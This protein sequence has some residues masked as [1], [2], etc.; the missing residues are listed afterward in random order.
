MTIDTTPKSPLDGLVSCGACG[1]PMEYEAPTQDHEASYACRSVHTSGGDSRSPLRVEAHTT[2][3]VVIRSVL[4]AILTERSNFILESTIRNPGEQEDMGP[5][6]PSE[7]I[8]LLK[9]DP[10]FF[11]QAVKGMENARNFLA[12]FIS[13]PGRYVGHPERPTGGARP[14]S[15][16]QILPAKR[17][18]CPGPRPGSIRSSRGTGSSP[19]T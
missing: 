13:R 11:L 2:D 14:L 15:R 16:S 6:F 19:A 5:Q 18:T 12:T 3:R 1:A 7:D 17:D 10:Y 4:E 9:E 8:S